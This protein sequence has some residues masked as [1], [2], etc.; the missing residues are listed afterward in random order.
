MYII[1]TRAYIYEQRQ[2]CRGMT[3]R[4]KRPKRGSELEEAILPPRRAD[5]IVMYIYIYSGKFLRVA[6][7]PDSD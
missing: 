2:L 4:G 5:A 7:S 6:K 1:Y 3:S